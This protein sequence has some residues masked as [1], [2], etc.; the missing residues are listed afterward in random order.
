MYRAWRP[1]HTAYPGDPAPKGRS[2]WDRTSCSYDL[3]RGVRRVI[4]AVLDLQGGVCP[5]YARVEIGHH[6]SLARDAEVLPDAISAYF[7]KA[8]GQ[9]RQTQARAQ[10]L[11]EVVDAVGPNGLNFRTLRQ[12]HGGLEITLHHETIE[13]PKALVAVILFSRR[14][15]S[16][17]VRI[18]LWLLDGSFL[19]LLDEGLA[20]L[21]S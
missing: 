18:P 9:A 1:N 7:G 10:G 17:Y 13:Y 15:A 3:G 5:I 8:P 19:E 12:L 6:H 20:P 11:R 16:R 4:A 14:R 2:P 21:G